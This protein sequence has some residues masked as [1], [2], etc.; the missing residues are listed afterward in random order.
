MFSDFTSTRKSNLFLPT[1]SADAPSASL[2]ALGTTKGSTAQVSAEYLRQLE[3]VGWEVRISGGNEV[4]GAGTL[5]AMSGG[6][7][8][9]LKVTDD[10]DGI[11]S[12]VL[13]L[14]NSR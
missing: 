6:R 9:F 13:T 14:G 4:S 1:Y 11:A 2:M 3:E 10:G 5:H 7:Q 8:L 12:V